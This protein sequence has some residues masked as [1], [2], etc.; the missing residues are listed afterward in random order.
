MLNMWF[1]YSRNLNVTFNNH[2]ALTVL[3]GWCEAAC[4]GNNTGGLQH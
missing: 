4:G 1:M 2:E 3:F